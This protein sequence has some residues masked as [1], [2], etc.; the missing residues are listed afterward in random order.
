[1][2]KRSWIHVFACAWRGIAVGVR[3]ERNFVVHFL[4][5]C[6]A[7]LVGLRL[8]ISLVEWALISLSIALVMSAEL[9][10]SALERLAKAITRE[11]NPLIR[12]ALDMA[13]GAVFVIALGATV[14]G[15][16][17]FGGRLWALWG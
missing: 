4:T 11:E 16:C 17:I 8:Q 10:N 6:A 15:G 1:M 9:F 12:D 14:V 5:A 13:A 3:T 7:L 2:Q